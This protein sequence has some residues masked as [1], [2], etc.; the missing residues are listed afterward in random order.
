MAEAVGLESVRKR[1]GAVTALD[2][3]SVSVPSGSFAAVLGPSG[4]GKSSLLHAIAGLVRPDSGVVRLND[5]VV[6]PDVP[7][8]SRGVGMMFQAPTLFPHM[9]VFENVAF[10]LR[11]RG[12]PDAEVNAATQS[13]LQL[14]DLSD[15]SR[16]SPKTLSGGQQQRVALCRALVF[17]PSVVLLDE[18]LSS[19]DRPLRESL[20][21]ELLKMQRATSATFIM[22]THDRDEAMALADVVFVMQEG[23]IEQ[24]GPPSSLYRA[25]VN[26]FVAE[27]FGGSTVLSGD[28]H[29]D[30]NLW[31]IVNADGLKLHSSAGNPPSAGKMD[32]A[33]KPEDV[34]IR[35]HTSNDAAGNGDCLGRIEEVRF[36]GPS[37]LLIVSCPSARLLARVDADDSEQLADGDSVIISVN[38]ADTVVI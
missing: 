2:Q 4:C 26:R 24:A 27:F 35:R 38:S 15:Y 23:R 21:R 34:R 1:Y 14:A 5:K 29:A 25:P 3:V 8:E 13:I 31:S 16:A 11:V 30:S 17:R 33:I 7:P 32:V 9:S 37:V 12:T 10:P 28:L 6:G 20:Q 18:P 19:L 36:T 22:V